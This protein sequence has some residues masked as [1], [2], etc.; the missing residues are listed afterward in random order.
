MLVR[1]RFFTA[2]ESHGQCLLAIVD[3]V[4]S[5]LELSV[6]HINSEL[7]RRQVGYG[8]SERMRIEH[9]KVELLSG[10]RHGKTI[11]SPIAMRIAN[12][13]YENWK[14]VMQPEALIEQF[15][16]EVLR[17]FFVPRPGHADLAGAIKYAHLDDLR[18][19][20]ER[21]SA[22]ETAARVAVG[23]VAKR[24]CERVGIC[25][26]SHVIS[27]G[28][29]KASA[30]ERMSNEE[31]REVAEKSELRCADAKAELR[32]KRLIDEAAERGDSVGGVLEVIAC[33]V[34]IGLGSYSQWDRRLDARLAYAVMSIQGIKGV[35]I[36][37]G[38]AST[39]LFGSQV[40]DEF[41]E[42]QVDVEGSVAFARR[43]N[44]AGGIEGG[45]S[46]GM[47]ILVRAAMKPIATL[48]KPLQSVDLRTLKLT[49]AHVERADVCAVPAAAVVAEA[50]VAIVLADAVLEKFGGDSVEE[51]ER[52]I[53]AH[54]EW[55][56]AEMRKRLQ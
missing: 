6:E 30:H 52:N 54:N 53:K 21:A 38:F 26:F 9:D 2:G 20:L 34:P 46:N 18:N 43:T 17:R 47:P 23:A 33:G 19:V 16:D 14:L 11:G 5:G 32:M 44:N 56:R 27:I 39:R 45:I 3:G 24:L 29:V 48:R 51:L 7:S 40:H 37:L 15:G 4:P 1:F 13:D 31:I 42:P 55:L 41:L 25:I 28:S 8:R 10:V 22:R 36:G 50:M 12:R 49:Q 35:E